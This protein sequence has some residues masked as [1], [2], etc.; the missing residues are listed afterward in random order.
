ML[1]EHNWML[2]LF[3]SLSFLLG[4]EA[5]RFYLIVEMGMKHHIPFPH[6]PGLIPQSP[7]NTHSSPFQML[8]QP[9]TEAQIYLSHLLVWVGNKLGMWGWE[10]RSSA[11]DCPNSQ[12]GG[13]EERRLAHEWEI[14][15]RWWG[16]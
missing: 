3:Q 6:L 14:Q 13:G 15:P 12:K 5:R 11:G 10:T 9:P 4:S 1:R 7:A 16:K 8:V 2:D